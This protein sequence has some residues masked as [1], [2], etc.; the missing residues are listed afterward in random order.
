VGT[1]HLQH[2]WEQLRSSFWFVPALLASAGGGLAFCLVAIDR[3]SHGDA[4]FDFA[5]IYGGGAAGARG[6]LAAI[7][8]SM[9]TVAGVVFSITTVALTLASQ[10]FGPRLLR[11]FMKDRGNQ[12]VLGTFIATF[13]YCLL[14]LRTVRGDGNEA[15]VPTHAVTGAV[16][17]AIFALGVLI[18]F[19]HHVARSIQ[20]SYVIASVGAELER[21]VDR[22][23]PQRIGRDAASRRTT[24]RPRL[25]PSFRDIDLDGVPD[26]HGAQRPGAYGGQGPGAYGGQGPGAYGGQGPGAYG[27]QRPGACAVSAWT[28]GY[29]QAVDGDALLAAA[30]DCNLVLRLARRPGDMVFEGE[31]LMHAWPVGEV[32]DA[33]VRR[34]RRAVIVGSE[35]PIEQDAKFAFD[36]LVEVALRALSPSMNDPQSAMACTDR[37]G[38]GLRKL[39]GREIPSGYRYDSYGCVRVIAPPTTF[40]QIA[41]DTLRTLQQHARQS[42]PVTLRLLS[43]IEAVSPVVCRAEDRAVLVRQAQ[44]IHAGAQDGLPDAAD[45]AAARRS[46]RAVQRALGVELPLCEQDAR[47]DRPDGQPASSRSRRVAN[48]RLALPNG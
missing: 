31:P 43:T 3:L 17:L 23:F 6:V 11:R 46:F 26:H 36:Q 10:Q 16:V 41:E 12:V 29:V 21:A 15:F 38:A 8:G 2:L 14:V 13:V 33:V 30:G 47:P 35:R 39:A 42:A 25:P 22:L 7:A 20:A 45:R 4:A 37:L 24:E 19:V 34:L 1:T 18:Y 48:E 5:W 27:G 9:I 44:R 40:A 28:S 32:S